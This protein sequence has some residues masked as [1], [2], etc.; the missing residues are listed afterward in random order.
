MHLLI[1]DNYDSFTYNLV[2]YFEEQGCEVDV[3]KNDELNFSVISNYDGIV[4]SPGPGLPAESGKLMEVIVKFYDLKPI[5]GVCLGMQAL[6]LFFGGQLVNQKKVKHGKQEW[7]NIQ[8][9]SKLLNQIE[10]PF[11]VGLY[12]SWEL[13]L[14]ENGRLKPI[15]FS[16][17]NVLMVIEHSDFP[18]Y[19]VQFHPESILTPNGKKIISNFLSVVRE[20]SIKY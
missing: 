7:I 8:Q 2:H 18:I 15:A 13:Q 16:E 1:V 5:L 19:G 9:S 10:S 14:S 17:N 11:Q 3:F 6:G 12:H 20:N 4:L